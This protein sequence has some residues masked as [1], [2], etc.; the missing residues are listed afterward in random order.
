MELNNYLNSVINDGDNISTNTSIN[1]PTNTSINTP[2]N[3]PINTPTN[4]PTLIQTV[5]AEVQSILGATNISTLQKTLTPESQYLRKLI[6]LDSD[7]QDE[8]L[9]GTGKLSW[10]LANINNYQKGVV[11]TSGNIRNIVGMRLFPPRWEKIDIAE[12]NK[13]YINRWTILVEEF[14]TQ[15][16]ISPTGNRFH[17]MFTY[18]A[19]SDLDSAGVYYNFDYS[20]K[21]FNKGYYWFRTPFTTVDKMTLSF[22]SAFNKF[23]IKT[24]KA[25][26]TIVQ[27]S[28]PM[29]I[30]FETSPIFFTGDIAE[31]NGFTTGDPI[32]DAA[33]IEY[34]NATWTLTAVSRFKLTIPVDIS[35]MVPKNSNIT[36]SVKIKR[37]RMTFPIELIYLSEE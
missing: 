26:G 24:N 27:N 1:T 35:T 25:Y 6:V 8:F 13:D 23:N 29:Q 37:Y 30:D 18:Q 31:I 12:Y 20:L 33:L 10:N 3:T 21:N 17:F 9:S 4:T 5:T 2:T 19:E 34:V 14:A 28:N 36:C 15:S 16:F 22:T 32:A 7:E 11:C